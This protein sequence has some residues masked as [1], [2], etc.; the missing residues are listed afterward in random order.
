MI[1]YQYIKI[2]QIPTSRS[3]D[4]AFYVMSRRAERSG[5]PTIYMSVDV[6]MCIGSRVWGLYY[7][8]YGV[9]IRILMLKIDLRGEFIT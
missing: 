7:R 5:L 8:L 3:K 9:N 1:I 4:N 6:Y 2:Y